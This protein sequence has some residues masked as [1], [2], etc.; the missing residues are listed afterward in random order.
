[1]DEAGDSAD[2]TGGRAAAGG[3]VRAIAAREMFP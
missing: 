1:M 3:R 2:V